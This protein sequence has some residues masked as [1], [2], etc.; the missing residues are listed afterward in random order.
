MC[1][2]KN[3]V[4]DIDDENGEKE[5]STKTPEESNESPCELKVLMFGN[6]SNKKTAS[7]A[8]IKK[9]K[10]EEKKKEREI[11]VVKDE[12]AVGQCSIATIAQKQKEL[13]MQAEDSYG[14]GQTFVIYNNND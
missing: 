7:C 10:E 8:A 14:T 11:E 6:P 2:L 4:E 12:G 3:N 13:D 5:A 1:K 9:K